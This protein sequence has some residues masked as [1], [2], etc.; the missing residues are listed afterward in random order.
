MLIFAS[1]AGAVLLNERLSLLRLE[2]NGVRGRGGKYIAKHLPGLVS[3]ILHRDYFSGPFPP[4]LAVLGLLSPLERWVKR[5]RKGP[6]EKPG[7]QKQ[8]RVCAF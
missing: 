7:L 4:S 6:R 5:G 8:D 3:Q 2:M 1:L